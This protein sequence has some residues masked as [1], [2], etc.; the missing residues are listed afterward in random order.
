MKFKKGEVVTSI[1]II[2]NND[3]M[4]DEHGM[5]VDA[6]LTHE[7]KWFIPK[8]SIFLVTMAPPCNYVQI[9]MLDGSC[10]WCMD[11]FFRH[12]NQAEQFLY[13]INNKPV[14]AKD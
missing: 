10:V 5:P 3:V 11:N 2:K 4:N 14:I 7:K 8:D 12:A 6:H 9:G 1:K 13:L